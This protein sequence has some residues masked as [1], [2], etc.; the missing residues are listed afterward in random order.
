[1]DSF[2][3]WRVKLSSVNQYPGLRPFYWGEIGI[4]NI[5]IDF[6]ILAIM[7]R[8]AAA[9][10]IDSLNIENATPTRKLC[11]VDLWLSG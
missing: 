7:E 5:G 10:C 11:A 8:A 4:W 6:Q 3:T 9:K 2:T 1:M